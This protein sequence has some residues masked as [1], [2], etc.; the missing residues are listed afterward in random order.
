MIKTAQQYKEQRES[1]VEARRVVDEAATVVD[2]AEH[3]NKE[4]ARVDHAAQHPRLELGG[5]VGLLGVREVRI[6]E[7]A[8]EEDCRAEGKE[9]HLEGR[10]G[11]ARVQLL[12]RSDVALGEL[13]A[14]RV[15]TICEVVDVVAD[16]G[17]LAIVNRALH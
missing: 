3:A 15:V 5:T 10:E 2:D 12:L 13:E 7:E 6:E 4:D 1:E 9:G 8:R 17:V 11:A 16:H 14:V